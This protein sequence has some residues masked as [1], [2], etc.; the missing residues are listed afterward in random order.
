MICQELRRV[1]FRTTRCIFLA[2][3][4]R[5]RLTPAEVGLEQRC[6]DLK[7]VIDLRPY[8]QYLTPEQAT[9]TTLRSAGTFAIKLYLG[10][11]LHLNDQRPRIVLIHKQPDQI[12]SMPARCN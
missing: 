4:R 8:L 9:I 12:V 10:L 2:G 7:W 1:V 5:S 11:P 6:F 3:G